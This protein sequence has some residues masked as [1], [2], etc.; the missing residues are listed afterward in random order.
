M[1]GSPR[2]WTGIL[3]GAA[4]LLLTLAALAAV[5]ATLLHHDQAVHG[6]VVLA[7]ITYALGLALLLAAGLLAVRRP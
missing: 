6:P 4:C 1:P 7:G 5:T 3:A 2:L